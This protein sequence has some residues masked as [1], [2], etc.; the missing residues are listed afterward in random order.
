MYVCVHVCLKASISLLRYT[1]STVAC[2]VA[3]CPLRYVLEP[4][5]ILM[6]VQDGAVAWKIKDFL[7]NLD[8]CRDVTIEGKVYDGKRKQVRLR[9]W[10]PIDVL[11][12][13]PN[14]GAWCG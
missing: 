12:R 11:A 4:G 10:I 3:C 5:K 9:P 14:L 1:V 7:V 6:V 2:M 8:N 13:C